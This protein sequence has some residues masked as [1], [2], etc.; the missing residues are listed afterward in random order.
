MWR[1]QGEVG[2]GVGGSRGPG[3]AEGSRISEWKLH[4]I[5]IST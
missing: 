4:C 5:L 2:G 3:E 1:V